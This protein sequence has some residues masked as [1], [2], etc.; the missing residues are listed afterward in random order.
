MVT[1]YWPH[2]EKIIATYGGA[3]FGMCFSSL[4]KVW[5]N[6]ANI[7]VLS[8]GYWSNKSPIESRVR[9]SLGLNYNISFMDSA[10]IVKRSFWS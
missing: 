4:M 1:M 8:L 3:S 6:W 10:V 9:F 5:N 7:D 2:L